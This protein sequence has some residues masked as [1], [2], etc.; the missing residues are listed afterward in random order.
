[1]SDENTKNL[2]VNFSIFLDPKATEVEYSPTAVVPAETKKKKKSVK[3][4]DDPEKADNELSAMQTN[5]AYIDSYMENNNA[6]KGVVVEIDQAQNMINEELVKIKKSKTMSKKYDYISSLVTTKSQLFG[7]KI[8]AIKEIGNN[9]TQS[10]NL[11]LKRQKELHITEEDDDKQVLDLYKSFISTPKDTVPQ[12][13]NEQ[14]LFNANS[15]FNAIN[16]ANHVVASDVTPQQNMMLLEN[17]PN[18]KT[19]LVY[20]QRTGNKWFDVQNLATGESIPNVDLPGKIMLDNISIDTFNNVA[21]DTK[22]D[23]TYPIVYV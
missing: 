11:E 6:L 19:V 8:S 17:N 20:E 15:N 16:T 18:V 2:G 23:I 5:D 10:H 4:S 14:S 7:S 21:R 9:I 22:L 3:K 12:F 13:M 1:M